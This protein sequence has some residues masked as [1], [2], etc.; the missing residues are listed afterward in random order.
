MLIK[1][2]CILMILML[3]DVVALNNCLVSIEEKF[4][5]QQDF[6]DDIQDIISI[7]LSD[8]NVCENFI[9]YLQLKLNESIQWSRWKH[10]NPERK[11][12]IFSYLLPL[13][14]NINDHQLLKSDAFNKNI[15]KTMTEKSCPV[16]FN[17]MLM[18][19]QSLS[20]NFEDYLLNFTQ[21][22]CE[23]II[24]LT[25]NAT[26]NILQINKNDWNQLTEEHKQ[27]TI[28]LIFPL[29]YINFKMEYS[30]KNLTTLLEDIGLMQNMFE[31]GLMIN[32]NNL[33]TKYTKGKNIDSNSL[34]LLIFFLALFSTLSVIII[35]RL[36]KIIPSFSK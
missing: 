2:N 36:F 6:T 1:I 21:N 27:Q 8:K 30:G 34:H 15:F 4:G 22:Q 19:K 9:D 32:N 13:L 25:Q 35:L 7:H 11:R 17:E 31:S 20:D 26:F 28:K 33:T 5:F 29:V 14:H 3:K 24:Y 12:K 23:K 18:L 16:L 10:F